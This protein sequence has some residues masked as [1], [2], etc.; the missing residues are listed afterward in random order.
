MNWETWAPE[1]ENVVTMRGCRISSRA[2]SWSSLATGWR[3]KRSR[4]RESAR[5]IIVSAGCWPR[6][7]ATAATVRC[8]PSTV[9]KTRIQS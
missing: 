9:S 2:T 8:G 1:S 7:R 4:S 6:S 5:S 3:K